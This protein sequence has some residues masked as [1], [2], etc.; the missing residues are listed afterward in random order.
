[1]YRIEGDAWEKRHIFEGRKEV[2]RCVLDFCSLWDSG[3]EGGVRDGDIVVWL[4]P[5]RKSL[6]ST[7]Q[8]V[9]NDV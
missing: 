1:L 6:A 8:E 4:I 9:H 7:P 3:R 5:E 2:G